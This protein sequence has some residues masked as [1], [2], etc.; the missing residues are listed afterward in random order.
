MFTVWYLIRVYIILIKKINYRG[1][2]GSLSQREVR[3]YVD[4]HLVQKLLNRQL[5]AVNLSELKS[6]GGLDTLVDFVREA[7][8]VS[9]DGKNLAAVKRLDSITKDLIVPSRSGA[10][11]IN[12]LLLWDS[13]LFCLYLL[14][15]HIF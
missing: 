9:W 7:F 13:K 11:I 6:N 15:Y 12:F 14:T 2:S 3:D 4:E 1:S 10:N 8:T 5:A